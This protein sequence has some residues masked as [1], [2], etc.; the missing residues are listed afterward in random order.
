MAQ[1]ETD[2]Q[3]R[4]RQLD[5]LAFNVLASR[6]T[7]PESWMRWTDWFEL[8]KAKCGDLGLGPATFSDCIRRLLKQGKVEKSQIAKNRFYRVIF[9][10]GSLLEVN[11]PKSEESSVVLDLAAQALEQLNRKSSGVV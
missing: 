3:R 2:K 5:H 11:L 10:S 8:T 9:T 1:P 4:Q 7:G 6:H